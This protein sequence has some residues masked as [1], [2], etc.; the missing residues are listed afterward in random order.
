MF[1][2]TQVTP[3]DDEN[4]AFEKQARYF[5]AF[6][7][8]AEGEWSELHDLMRPDYVT[9]DDG[10]DPLYSMCIPDYN[11]FLDSAIT[12]QSQL[13]ACTYPVQGAVFPNGDA[14]VVFPMTDDAGRYRLATAEFKKVE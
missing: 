12:M 1:V 7:Y 8:S 5:T 9:G 4:E 3:P 13:S 10:V 11:G 6:R 14:V 2:L